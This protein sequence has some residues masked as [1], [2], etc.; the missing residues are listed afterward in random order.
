M[1]QTLIACVGALTHA[2]GSMH[3]E[4]DKE[5][6]G[7]GWFKDLFLMYTNVNFLQILY[8]IAKMC[9]QSAVKTVRAV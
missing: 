2:C 1:A 4:Q 9:V 8:A 5:K 6:G 7:G 3:K